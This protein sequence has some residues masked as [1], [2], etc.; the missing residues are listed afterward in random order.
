MP[1]PSIC[2]WVEIFNIFFFFFLCFFFC[3]LKVCFQR[4]LIS[5][6]HWKKRKEWKNFVKKKMR[7]KLKTMKNGF[8]VTKRRIRRR[9]H[10]LQP[11]VIFMIFFFFF[12]FIS[13]YILWFLTNST[14]IQTIRKHLH[15]DSEHE[16]YPW[17]FQWD[18]QSFRL[19]PQ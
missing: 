10:L 16:L 4:N 2:K 3:Y 8:L 12:F 18:F 5:W 19:I 14:I 1:P 7:K 17:R 9:K 13:F 11:L 6:S 15:E